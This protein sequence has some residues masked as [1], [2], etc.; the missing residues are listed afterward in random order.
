[1]NSVPEMGPVADSVTVGRKPI[2]GGL[3]VLVGVGEGVGV[4]VYVGVG[5]HVGVAVQVGGRS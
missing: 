1:M 5:V 2:N 3:E 4:G